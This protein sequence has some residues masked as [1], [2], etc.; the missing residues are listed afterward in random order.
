[1]GQ[2]A[3]RD[4]FRVPGL[5]SLARIPLALV[6]PV[7][8]GRPA[9]AI[10]VLA[11]AALTDVADGWY[12]R[13]FHQETPTGRVLDPITDKVFVTV[14]AVTMIAA[15]AL[16]VMEALLLASRE[17]CELALIAYGSV[18]WRGRPRSARAANRLGKLATVMQFATVAALIIGTPHRTVFILATAI[19][20]VVAG[21]SYTLREARGA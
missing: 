6:F 12:A 3:A 15:G 4:V 21:L 5:L 10:A 9:L 14:V 11:L 17:V 20:G 7:A 16:S 1:M 18:V 8:L 2:Y 19:V 13:R